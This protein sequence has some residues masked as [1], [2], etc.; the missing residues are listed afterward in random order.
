M[1]SQQQMILTKRSLKTGPVCNIREQTVG[2]LYIQEELGG[3]IWN[4]LSLSAAF[5]TVMCTPLTSLLSFRG[6]K[7]VKETNTAQ[8][9]NLF[10]C[11]SLNVHHSET[12]RTDSMQQSPS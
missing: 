11:M 3:G 8:L 9:C 1:R 12:A 6:Y 2:D 5:F 10:L 7:S 4:Y